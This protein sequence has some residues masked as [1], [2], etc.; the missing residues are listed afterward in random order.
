MHHLPPN[1]VLN[2][3]ADNVDYF[4]KLWRYDV[5]SM[6]KVAKNTNIPVILMTYPI[7]ISVP[8]KEFLSVA[9]KEGLLLIRNDLNFDDLKKRGELSDYILSRDNWH[10]TKKGYAIVAR[11]V[12][13]AIVNKELLSLKYSN[14][15]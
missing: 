13:D 10:P 2:T 4:I 14:K 15:R 11:N 9:E 5:A 8:T 6:I 12:F 3:F 7:P 1:W